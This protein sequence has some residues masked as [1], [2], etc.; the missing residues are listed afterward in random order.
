[1][2]TRLFLSSE[3]PGLVFSAT[4]QQGILAPSAF[5][6][7]KSGELRLPPLISTEKTAPSRQSL[8]KSPALRVRIGVIQAFTIY[9][10]V[11]Q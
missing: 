11:K 6:P 5:S 7:D 4:Y 8:P 2:R 1:M 10:E 9:M 3:A